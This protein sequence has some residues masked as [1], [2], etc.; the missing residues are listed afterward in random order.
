MVEEANLLKQT[1]GSEAGVTGTLHDGAAITT[2]MSINLSEQKWNEIVKK[3][4]YTR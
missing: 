3:H 2:D 1:I 4:L